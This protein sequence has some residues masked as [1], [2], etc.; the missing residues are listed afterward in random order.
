MVSSTA[1]AAAPARCRHA[2]SPA[3]RIQGGCLL[4][5]MNPCK[6]SLQVY[7]DHTSLHIVDD[8][9]SEKLDQSDKD[10]F[11]NMDLLRGPYKA[12]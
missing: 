3:F 12:N 10:A 11:L 7:Q 2:I 6:V 1:A 4:A 8:I 5:G 9:V